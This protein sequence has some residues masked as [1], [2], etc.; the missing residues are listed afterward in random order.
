MTARFDARMAQHAAWQDRAR[1][2]GYLAEQVAAGRLAFV[3]GAGVSE[4]FGLPDWPTLVATLHAEH[5]MPQPATK[6]ERQVELLRQAHYP[7]DEAGYLNAVHHAL[8]GDRTFDRWTLRANRTLAA[9]ANTARAVA[10]LGAA[11]V[12][13]F[14]FD[15]MLER[16]LRLHGCP[17][18]II[19]SPGEAAVN[20]DV[21]VYHPHGVLPVDPTAPRTP[22]VFDQ[23]SFSTWRTDAG[24]AWR[25]EILAVF[26]AQ[27]CV[28]IGL[29]GEDDNLDQLLVTARDVHFARDNALPYWGVRVVSGTP[30]D[31]AL[32][33]EGRGISTFTVADYESDLPSLLFDVCEQAA[34]KQ[35]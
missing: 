24:N 21:K 13:T 11:N 14:N 9:V 17:S 6:L 31:Q 35:Q 25:Q 23:E 30:Q 34:A 29:S 20:R 16:Y 8:Y 1:L 2:T 19:T 33:E 28:F 12:V 3:L 32:W 18:W 15:D 4:P 26:R 27:L 5:D 7:N 22:I 10:R